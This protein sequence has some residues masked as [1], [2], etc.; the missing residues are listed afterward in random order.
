MAKNTGIQTNFEGVEKPL[1]HLRSLIPRYF[2]LFLYLI[3]NKSDRQYS[4]YVL[5]FITLEKYIILLTQKRISTFG[6]H[7]DL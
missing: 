3:A 7:Y 1:S 6:S 4:F 5:V 2:L